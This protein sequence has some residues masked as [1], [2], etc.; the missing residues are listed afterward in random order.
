MPKAS[1]RDHL[2]SNFEIFDFALTTEEFDRIDNIGG[3]LQLAYK[4][5]V[6]MAG[7]T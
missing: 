3:W 7:L 1:S 4:P 5:P 2:L 6:E